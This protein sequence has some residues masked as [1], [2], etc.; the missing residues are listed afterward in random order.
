MPTNLTS[1]DYFV[2]FKV[3]NFDCQIQTYIFVTLD[4]DSIKTFR[5]IMG[6]N[7]RNGARQIW[8]PNL[9]NVHNDTLPKNFSVFHSCHFYLLHGFFDV[10]ASRVINIHKYPRNKHTNTYSYLSPT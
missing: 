6:S 8:A 10:I 7:Q 3:Q 5:K 2:P 4:F 9:N 1:L